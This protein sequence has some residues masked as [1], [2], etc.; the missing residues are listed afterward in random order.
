MEQISVASDLPAAGMAEASAETMARDRKKL[1]VCILL[2]LIWINTSKIAG[3]S[4]EYVPRD[5]FFVSQLVLYQEVIQGIPL[6]TTLRLLLIPSL[7]NG[8]VKECPRRVQKQTL[9]Q[10]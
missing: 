1:I 3:A 6:C 2:A 10:K 5:I 8:W 9:I 7:T 4:F